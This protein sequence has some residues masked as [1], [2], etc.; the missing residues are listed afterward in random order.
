MCYYTQDAYDHSANSR[1]GVILP[2][3]LIRAGLLMFRHNDLPQLL[4]KLEYACYTMNMQTI[5][6]QIDHTI[7]LLEGLIQIRNADIS[8]LYEQGYSAIQLAE[9]YGLTRQHV[10]RII[11][12]HKEAARLESQ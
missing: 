3:S 10:H 12:T 7:A 11:A 6:Q 1:A 9:M 5:T 8:K 4:D 2:T